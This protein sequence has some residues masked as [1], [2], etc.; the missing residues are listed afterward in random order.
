MTT[1]TVP[2]SASKSATVSGM[3]SPCS[4]MRAMMKWPGRAA[5]ATS[6]APTSQ[7]NVVGPNCSRRMIGYIQCTPPFPKS[8]WY[9]NFRACGIF[10][11]P[12]AAGPC[13]PARLLETAHGLLALRFHLLA[14][15]RALLR[16]PGG[17]GSCGLSAGACTG[18]G[19]FLGHDPCRSGLAGHDR[20]GLLHLF[21]DNW[22]RRKLGRRR[23]MELRTQIHGESL[24]LIGIDAHHQLVLRVVQQL[25]EFL[26]AVLLP[27]VVGMLLLDPLGDRFGANALVQFHAVRLQHIA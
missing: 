27:V 21:F 20:L 2:R 24:L 18:R 14:P 22:L 25:A 23:R 8:V 4:S 7:R 15:G 13:G 3:R 1:V 17:S 5:R 26:E 16:R 10:L 9:Q 6:A 11:Q 19:H 12:V